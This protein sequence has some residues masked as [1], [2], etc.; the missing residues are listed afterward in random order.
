VLKYRAISQLAAH[1][2]DISR[3]VAPA[4]SK[5]ASAP[6]DRAV[7]LYANAGSLTG[8]R[9]ADLDA[10]TGIRATSLWRVILWVI[11][12][13]EMRSSVAVGPRM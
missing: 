5:P 9:G 12:V 7:D 13:A 2:T 4:A 10:P 8:A 6:G 3:S 11:V 1:L